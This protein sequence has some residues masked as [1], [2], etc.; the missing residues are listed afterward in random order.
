VVGLAGSPLPVKASGQ[1][2]VQ[3]S[4]ASAPGSASSSTSVSISSPELTKPPSLRGCITHTSCTQ[5]LFDL[6]GTATKLMATDALATD[7]ANQLWPH[8]VSMGA[9]ASGSRKDGV[10]AT[11]GCGSR[12]MDNLGMIDTLHTN[13]IP[14]AKLPIEAM[15]LFYIESMSAWQY[16]CNWPRTAAEISRGLER[17][18][19]AEKLTQEDPQDWPRMSKLLETQLSKYLPEERSRF[20]PRLTTLRKPRQC[21]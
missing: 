13:H 8:I 3:L 18:W 12:S 10:R 14:F 5:T 17:I 19:N 1:L 21:S 2:A 4:S 6:P 9:S 15:A 11:F 20:E 16:H 7:R